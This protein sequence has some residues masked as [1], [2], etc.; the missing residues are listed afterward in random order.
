MAVKAFEATVK[1]GQIVLDMDVQLPENTIVYVLIP[2]DDTSSVVR[3]VS[4]RL[5]HRE[6]A[7]DFSKKVE[8]IDR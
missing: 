4:P 2:E 6:Q 8:E 3:I 1:N 5:V 7:V